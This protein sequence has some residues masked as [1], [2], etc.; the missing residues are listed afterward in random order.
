[1]AHAQEI[2]KKLNISQVVVHA[3]DFALSCSETACAIVDGPYCAHPKLSTGGGDN[4]NAGYCMG[5]ILEMSQAEALLLGT[6]TSGYYVRQA[7]SP[8][9]SNLATFLQDWAKD[10]IC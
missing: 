5:S 2:R 1:M 8:T 9:L 3:T 6:A 10:A 4:F 7:K